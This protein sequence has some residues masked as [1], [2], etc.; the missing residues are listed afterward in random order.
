[1]T[2]S[3]DGNDTLTTGLMLLGGGVAG[4]AAGR[5][6]VSRFLDERK[7]DGTKPATAPA[8]PP[9]LTTAP[10]SAP[11][12]TLIDPYPTTPTTPPAAPPTEPAPTPV[13]TAPSPAAPGPVSHPSLVDPN[14]RPAA[15]I[16]PYPVSAPGALPPFTRPAHVPS[17]PPLSRAFDPVFHTYRGAIPIEYLRALC[18]R[19]SD[20]NPAER[21]GPAWGL[22]QIIEAVR[23][24][25]N[26]A[27]RTLYR[28]DDLLDPRVNIAIGCWLLETII[29]SYAKHHPDVPNLRADWN[30]VRFAEL[31]TFGWNA[32]FS[33]KAGVGRMATYLKA[34]SLTVN[35]DNAHQYAELAKASR[36]LQ[37]A[38]KLRWCKGVAALYVRERDHAEAS[39]LTVA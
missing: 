14:V 38:K 34:H 15:L 12:R 1:M 19:E 33:E 4:F 16:D 35:I 13:P 18:T 21:K 2:T 39:G 26:R 5:F 3:G 10:A 9:S 36:H 20:M 7:T 25:Y 11:P 32:G 6:L 23:L 24:D 27:H 22:M 29:R 8:P 31:V 37:N 30:N 17:A 28:R